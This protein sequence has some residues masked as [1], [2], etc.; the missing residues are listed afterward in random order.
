MQL[1]R[2]SLAA[3]AIL[4]CAQLSGCASIARGITEAVMAGRGQGGHTQVLGAQPPPFVLQKSLG[5]FA[6]TYEINAYCDQPSA[7]A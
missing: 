2:I 1:K 5:D 3:L 4:E 7:M 6:V